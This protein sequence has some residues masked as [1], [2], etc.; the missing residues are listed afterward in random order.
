VTSGK[1][2]NAVGVLQTN[3]ELSPA[4]TQAQHIEP[5]VDRIIPDYENDLDS[6]RFGGPP[7]GEP[8][9]ELQQFS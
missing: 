1:E 5:P 3:G 6:G 4:T 2:T 9:G 7:A 8:D